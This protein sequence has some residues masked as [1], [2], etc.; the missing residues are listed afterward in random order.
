MFWSVHVSF[1]DGGPLIETLEFFEISHGSDQPFNFLPY[2]SLSTQYYI[3]IPL[4]GCQKF[5]RTKH[6]SQKPNWTEVGRGCAGGCVYMYFCYCFGRR[7]WERRVEVTT[8]GALRE[9]Y[10]LHFV[11]INIKRKIDQLV[12]FNRPVLKDLRDNN[13]MSLPWFIP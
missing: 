11:V 6:Y 8:R 4:I 12:W 13:L 3:L 9:N 5:Y 2:L 7:L 1:S 10:S